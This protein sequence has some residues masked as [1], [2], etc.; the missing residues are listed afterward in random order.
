MA[1][2]FIVVWF[3]PAWT[4]LV[5]SA[6]LASVPALPRSSPAFPP[7]PTQALICAHVTPS[8]CQT[9]RFPAAPPRHIHAA[10]LWVSAEIAFVQVAF[11]HHSPIVKDL[12]AF[13]TFFNKRIRALLDPQGL[14][15]QRHSARTYQMNYSLIIHFDICMFACIFLFLR[16]LQCLFCWVCTVQ[17][18]RCQPH[19]ALVVWLSHVEMCCWRKTHI[20]F[21]RLTQCFNID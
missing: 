2:E 1:H 18:G 11:S 10:D 5:A 9:G 20:K 12:I 15:H 6:L 17:Y 16:F 13:I 4:A 8:V 7:F 3:L 19:V 21:Q 14:A